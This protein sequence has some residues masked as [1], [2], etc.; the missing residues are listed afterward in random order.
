LSA[1]DSRLRIGRLKQRYSRVVRFYD[2]H[3]H[4]DE[5]TGNAKDLHWSRITAEEKTHLGG[6]RS[7]PPVGFASD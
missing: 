2:I 7:D 1:G 3:V 4:K 5:E 6:N